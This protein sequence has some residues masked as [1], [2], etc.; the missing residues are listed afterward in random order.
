M[1]FDPVAAATAVLDR[2]GANGRTVTSPLARRLAAEHGIDVTALSGS[3]MRGRIRK[4]DVLA[5]IERGARPQPR[6]P[7]S[8]G[9]PRGYDDV[10]H[11][12]MPTSAA[13][14]RRSPST[15]SARARRAAHM[16]TEVEVDMTRVVRAREELNG[17]RRADGLRKLS[18]L[19]LIARA[20][21]AR[22]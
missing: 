2:A 12:V 22:R 15:W 4:A 20:P 3:G 19:P 18:Y 13:A 5:A 6:V 10:P 14:A 7:A 11:E 8:G 1:R 17:A 16:T 9:L 21:A